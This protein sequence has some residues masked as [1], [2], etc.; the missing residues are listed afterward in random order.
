LPKASIQSTIIVPTPGINAIKLIAPF[1][2]VFLK[3]RQ[4][5]KIV[6]ATIARINTQYASVKAERAAAAEEPLPLS[7][8]YSSFL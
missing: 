3:I 7:M 1:W 4:K 8:N 5:M 6:K 2:P